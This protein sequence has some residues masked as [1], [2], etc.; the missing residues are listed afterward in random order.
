MSKSGY[1]VNANA[2]DF[3]FYDYENSTITP[4]KMGNYVMGAP[5]APALQTFENSYKPIHGYLAAIVCVFGVLANVLNIIVLTRKNMISSTNIILTGL[6]VSD[7]LTMAFYFPFA[8]QMYVIHGISASPDRDTEA[9][10]KYTLTYAIASVILHSISIWLTVTL[11]VFR[12]VFIRFPR[13]GAQYCNIQ[14]AKT[15]VISVA[16]VVTI[17]CIPNSISYEFKSQS[18][19]PPANSSNMTSHPSLW[20]I[21]VRNST[22][23]DVV[24]QKFNFWVQAVLVK[25]LPCFLL[26]I[27][28]VLLVRTMQNAENRRKKMMTKNSVADGETQPIGGSTSSSKRSRRSQRTTR[29][30]LTVVILFL[31]TETPQGI[32]NLLSGLIQDFFHHIYTPLG[33][34]LDIL[35][36][37]NNGINFVLYCTM[38]KQFRDTFISIFCQCF[39]KMVEGRKLQTVTT[40]MV[41]E[42]L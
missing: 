13:I 24:L 21:D 28:S 26:T 9:N 36:L 37:I 7:G 1:Y 18:I 16:I 15:A 25:L 32:M 34:L 11:A 5:E 20:W 6:A 17:V 39:P 4:G 40:T 12:Y 2:T 10:A 41:T 35:A 30:L 27:F 31:V 22:H 33:D 23:S 14:R 42:G 38:S 3:I 19:E 29:M 8:L